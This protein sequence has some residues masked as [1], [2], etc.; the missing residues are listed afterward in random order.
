[1]FHITL[2]LQRRAAVNTADVLEYSVLGRVSRAA[3]NAAERPDAEMCPPVSGKV[4]ASHRTAAD[5]TLG[6]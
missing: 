2:C 5:I 4:G 6:Q 1:M 3:Q